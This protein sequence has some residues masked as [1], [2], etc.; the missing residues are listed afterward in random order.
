MDMLQ[1]GG[2]KLCAVFDKVFNKC[3]H[4]VLTSNEP[5]H[6]QNRV[7][8]AKELWIMFTI[9]SEKEKAFLCFP[10]FYFGPKS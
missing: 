6:L 10:V 9:M 8:V 1:I 3:R 5:G 2:R 4:L 7:M